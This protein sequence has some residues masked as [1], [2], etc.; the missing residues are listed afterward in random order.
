MESRVE[1]R[2]AERKVGG[3]KLHPAVRIKSRGWPAKSFKY[4]SD[5]F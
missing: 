1:N 4:E 3:A 5:R 2:S